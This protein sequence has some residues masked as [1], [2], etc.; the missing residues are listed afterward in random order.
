MQAVVGAGTPTSSG[1]ETLG[2]ID[3]LPTEVKV[4]IVEWLTDARDLLALRTTSRTWRLLMTGERGPVH[5][6]CRPLLP[7]EALDRLAAH[8]EGD[9]LAC[10]IYGVLGSSQTSLRSIAPIQRCETTYWVPRAKGV[11]CGW[12]LSMGD[13]H[14]S[15]G[16]PLQVWAVGRWSND[17]LFDG[18]TRAVDLVNAVY[19]DTWHWRSSPRTP[20]CRRGMRRAQWVGRVADGAAH[21]RGVWQASTRHR[22][23]RPGS[24]CGVACMGQWSKGALVS[25]TMTW[26][27]DHVYRGEFQNN[28][29]HGFGTLDMGHRA[30]YVGDWSMGQPHGNGTLYD[31]GQ[32]L[33]DIDLTPSFYS[34]GWSRGRRDGMGTKDWQDG[35]QYVGTWT[36]DRFNGRGS[37]KYVD[38]SRHDG[39]WHWGERHGRGESFGPDGRR[40]RRGYWVRDEPCSRLTYRHYKET[41]FQRSTTRCMLSIVA[42][43]LQDL[44]EWADK[45][46]INF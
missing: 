40:R 38:G 14:T 13:I 35:R 10:I 27:R 28:L 21:G 26:D 17:I 19:G 43:P 41:G 23:E 5:A 12:G 39:K 15:G 42:R 34:G 22:C 44:A 29:F 24:P 11:F 37:F 3:D 9:L 45:P 6:L 1:N 18:V 46:L 32:H 20:A 2:T 4:M 25:G 31:S 36:D 7:D 8:P 33:K 16:P 30:C